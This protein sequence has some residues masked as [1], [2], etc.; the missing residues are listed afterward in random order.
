M[1]K[2]DKTR[3][4]FDLAQNKDKIEASILVK[5]NLNQKVAIRILTTRK[6]LYNVVPTY[7]IIQPNSS[8]KIMF[9]LYKKVNNI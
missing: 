2:L 3:I 6:E 1:I 8:I 5:N 7:T 9:Y 4:E